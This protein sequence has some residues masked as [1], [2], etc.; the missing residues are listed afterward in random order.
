MATVLF[1]APV[2]EP[3]RSEYVILW[4]GCTVNDKVKIENGIDLGRCRPDSDFGRGFYTTTLERQARQWAWNRFYGD[5]SNNSGNQPVV[6]HFRVARRSLAELLFLSFVVGDFANDDYWSLVQHCRQSTPNDVRDHKGPR[7]G[8]YDTVSGP[9]AAYWEQ[10]ATM[11]DSDQV[12]FHTT[13]A[14]QLLND[15]V[16][17]GK[18]GNKDAYD[19]HPVP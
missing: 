12:S 19:W 10:R 18:N 5:S 16:T 14:I 13:Q 8:W 7:Q 3:T 4:H 2:W 11:D 1:P 6:L 15:I 17:L 9:V